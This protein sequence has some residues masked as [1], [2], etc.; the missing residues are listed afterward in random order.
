MAD[1]AFCTFP[2]GITSIPA[3]TTSSNCTNCRTYKPREH[4]RVEFWNRTMRQM[5]A[6]HRPKF[7]VD[8]FK[9]MKW[10]FP[11]QEPHAFMHL[12]P[13]VRTITT[14]GH[15]V[16]WLKTGLL[17]ELRANAEIDMNIVQRIYRADLQH[18]ERG[19]CNH[20]SVTITSMGQTLQHALVYFEGKRNLILDQVKSALAELRAVTDAM[21]LY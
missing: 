5:P 1:A 13:Q 9:I 3:W 12:F 7:V 8:L 2:R 14:N 16:T 18:V 19:T 20:T 15:Y 17:K 4:T 21:S 11:I 6:I 10:V